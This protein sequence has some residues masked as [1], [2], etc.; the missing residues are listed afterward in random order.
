MHLEGSILLDEITDCRIW[1]QDNQTLTKFYCASKWTLWRRGQEI[2][3]N[4]F[5]LKT[6]MYA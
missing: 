2:G 3:K 1:T 6:S 5:I 4:K